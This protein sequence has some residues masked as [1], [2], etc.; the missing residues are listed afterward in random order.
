MKTIN[1][2]QE[3]RYFIK[4][5]R[6]IIFDLDD[7]LYNEIE[8]VRS[9]FHEIGK[10]FPQYNDVEELLWRYYIK[11][12]APIDTFL[13]N[14]NIYTPFLKQKCLEV[15][16]MHNPQINLDPC[17]KQIL[18]ELRNKGYYLGIITDGRPDGQRK[19]IR[20]LRLNTLVDRII[21][22]D[23]LGG[24]KW[25]KPNPISFIKM[26]KGF[27]LQFQEGCYIGDNINK[28]F[29]APQILGMGSIWFK[30]KKGIYYSSQK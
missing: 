19:K 2:L 24:E 11:G 1:N 5:F 27:D 13:L 8:Y 30:N 18:I 22:T 16:R 26:V 20:A 9:G 3:L 28:D 21:V 6:L 15:Y 23:A 17:T 4:N 25:R 29:F 14:R 10:L 7:T 12:M